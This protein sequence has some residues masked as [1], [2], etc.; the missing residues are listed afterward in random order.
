MAALLKQFK[1]V[2]AR[3]ENGA[4]TEVFAEALRSSFVLAE[5]STN[6]NDV[7][8]DPA[9]FA[10]E[11]IKVLVHD[12]PLSLTDRAPE[13]AD[14]VVAE[15]RR[16]NFVAN[17]LPCDTAAQENFIRIRIGSRQNQ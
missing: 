13:A 15:L 5:W 3:V 14:A 4:D 8:V 11:G 16:Q 12:T 2:F 6:N 9:R 7:I 1:G 10:F 17:R